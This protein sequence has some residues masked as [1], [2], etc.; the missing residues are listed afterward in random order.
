MISLSSP[1]PHLPYHSLSWAAEQQITVFPDSQHTTS[2][3]ATY[4]YTCAHAQKGHFTVLAAEKCHTWNIVTY[5]WGSL[6]TFI[7]TY[8]N[9][10]FCWPCI[11]VYQYNETNVMHFSLNLLRIKGIYMFRAS[12]AHPQEAPYKPHLVYYVRIMSVG[13]GTVAV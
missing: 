6:P 8:V 10:M 11:I 7:V 4:S 2:Q 13:C 12:L 5:P 3:R 1:L 9:L